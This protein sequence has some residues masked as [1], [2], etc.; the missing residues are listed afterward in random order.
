MEIQ[1]KEF[2][3]NLIKQLVIDKNSD[4]LS[5]LE[6]EWDEKIKIVDA[7]LQIVDNK[8]QEVDKE[9]VVLRN[10]LTNKRKELMDL[11][12]TVSKAHFQLRK[13]KSEKNSVNRAFWRAR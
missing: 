8:R 9:Y 12:S 13:L 6:D 11:E 1:M 7:N 2:D 10:D 4:R 5:T 3:S